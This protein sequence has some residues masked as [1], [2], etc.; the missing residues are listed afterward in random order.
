MTSSY[1]AHVEKTGWMSWTSSSNYI[2]TV[3]K[4][5]RMEAFE[6]KL[7]GELASSVLGA[8]P[9]SRPG[10]RVAVHP[11]GRRDGWHHRARAKRIEAVKVTLVPRSDLT[12]MTSSGA[13]E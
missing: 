2:G 7:T 11:L 13:P 8:V 12:Q 3:G 1:R 9:G 6:I 5:L 4:G 10:Q